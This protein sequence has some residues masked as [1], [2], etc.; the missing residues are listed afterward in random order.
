MVIW[1]ML[2]GAFIGW[3]W[4]DFEGFGVLLGGIPG[5][6]AGLALRSIV[7]R[8]IAE[9]VFGLQV[10]LEALRAS[11]TPAPFAPEPVR[12]V[13]RAQPR[14]DPFLA[15]RSVAPPSVSIAGQTAN[16]LERAP[17]PESNGPSTLSAAFQAARDWLFGGNTVVRVGVVILFI[18]LAFLASYAASAGL[19][20]IEVRLALVALAGVALL[21]F[22]FRTRERRPNYA[23]ALQGTGIAAIYLTLYA[24]ARWY[25][26]ASITP[27]LVLMVAVCALAVA[28]ALLQASEAL[29]VLAF[30]GGF[31]APL[32]LASP[33]GEVAIL[34]GFYTLLN[35][36]VLALVRRR[37]WRVLG[38]TGFAA[39]FGMATL[40]Q[41]TGGALT[42]ADL[43]AGHVFVIGSVVLYALVALFATRGAERGG[44]LVEPAIDTTLLFG[45]A[46][47]GFGLELALLGDRP[48]ASAF[49]ALGF[50]ALYLALAAV[51]R[52]RGGTAAPLLTDALIAI[53]VGFVTVA[54]PLALGARWTAAVW[55]L[56]GAAAVWVGARQGRWL[57]RAFG[58]LLLAVAIGVFLSTL[59]V[60]VLA[61]APIV[62]GAIGAALIAIAAGLSAWWLGW[63]VAPAP[64][65]LG[66]SYEAVERRLAEPLFLLAF[67]AWCLACALQ[68]SRLGLAGVEATLLPLLTMLA[69]VVSAWCARWLGRRLD[70][71]VASWPSHGTVFV[72]AAGFAWRLL[73]ERSAVLW[74]DV[75]VWAAAGAVH[76]SCLF[77]CDR[78]A[79]PG[80]ERLR[81]VDHVG[82][83]W[84]GAALLIDALVQAA[85]SGGLG[86][87]GWSDAAPLVALAAALFVLARQA[88][89]PHAGGRGW[90]W[91]GRER[92][93]GWLAAAPL[94]VLLLIAAVVVGLASPGD[95]APLPYLPLLNPVDLALGLAVLTVVVWR[96]AILSAEPAIGGAEVLDELKALAVLG[97]VAFVL[98]NTAWLRASHQLLGVGWSAPALMSS[99]TVQAGLA[100][101]WTALALALMVAAHRQGWRALWLAGAALLALTVLKLLAVDL[102]N[103]GGG[104][105]I[106]TFIGVGALMLVIG[107]AAPL[108]PRGPDEESGGEALGEPVVA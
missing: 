78:Q 107:Y 16:E 92:D 17:E 36:G 88:L 65:P 59:E 94:A 101:G 48:F 39:T 27:A 55:A 12:P 103:I 68:L 73:A 102:G 15:A 44:S 74:P 93:Y 71:P 10:E 51:D 46:V 108:P 98:V 1:G 104:A 23:V 57:P 80:T 7:R 26:L 85:R 5:A 13:T 62:S 14:D 84:L 31:A 100:I 22:G 69:V 42:E 99:F 60:P 63:P 2:V 56:E 32:L 24:A 40:W 43:V 6:L 83:A 18:G 33:D 82:T 19:F 76:L 8:E 4:C 58:L 50:A 106:V 37:A 29:A 11:A 79:Q 3:I 87:T 21:G 38:L 20:P 35:L 96:T 75:A 89:P 97:G 41:V 70:W 77:E 34:F 45:P 61:P 49:A 72:L 81:R 30:A 47:A 90:P 95:A 54:V 91:R 66:R 105:R 67:A 53:A 64:S 9:R 25:G 86:G 28:L 52:R